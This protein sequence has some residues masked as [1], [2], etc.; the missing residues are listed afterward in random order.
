MSFLFFN[1]FLYVQDD[2][3]ETI[4]DDLPSLTSIGKIKSIVFLYLG[5]FLSLHISSSFIFL[6]FFVF[7][8]LFFFLSTHFNLSICFYTT[9]LNKEVLQ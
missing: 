4:V 1:A 3:A 8:S 2:E 9:Y 6:F 5:V 7:L